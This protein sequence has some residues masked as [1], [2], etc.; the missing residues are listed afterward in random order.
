MQFDPNIR[1]QCVQCGKSCQRDWDIWVRPELPQ[2]IRSSY[3]E[4]ASQ[5]ALPFENVDER[6]RIR[7]NSNGCVCLDADSLCEI[8]RTLSYDHKPYRCQQ[9]PVMLLRTPDGLRVSASYTCT[10]VLS[11][12]GPPLEQLRPQVQEWSQGS[13]FVEEVGSPQD[14]PDVLALEEHFEHLLAQSGWQPALEQI[15]SGLL[16]GHLDQLPGPPLT[17]W[18]GYRNQPTHLTHCLPWLL[19]ALLKPCFKNRDPE[20]WTAFDSAMQ[21]KSGRLRL[22]EFTY[23][24]SAVQLLDWAQTPADSETE[25]E[26]YRKSLWFRRQHLRCGGILSGFLMLWSVQPLYRVL[27]RLDGCHAAI[28]RIELNL[29]GHSQAAPRVFPLL[30]KFWLDGFPST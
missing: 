9:Y 18:K 2:Q 1:Y 22:D 15:L 25:L 30:G 7:R 28:E 19:S 23:Q 6:W 27:S 5:A 20:V 13:F 11:R 16:S 29:L 10:A 24:G 26:Y 12:H 4:I 17:W 21:N 3:R 8:H 14:W